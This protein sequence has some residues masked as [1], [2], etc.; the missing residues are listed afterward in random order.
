MVPSEHIAS[1]TFAGISRAV[2]KGRH[3]HLVFLR[4]VNERRKLCL[5]IRCIGKS[6]GSLCIT[7]TPCGGKVRSADQLHKLGDDLSRCVTKNYVVI[8]VSVIYVNVAVKV[9]VVVMFTTEIKSAAGQG[10]VVQAHPLT[11]CIAA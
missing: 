10:V 8:Q 6:H 7:Q 11:L 2:V 9:V 3:G 5:C 4:F 1:L